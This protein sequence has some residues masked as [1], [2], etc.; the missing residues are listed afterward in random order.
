MFLEGCTQTLFKITEGFLLQTAGVLKM[1]FT[2]YMNSSSDFVAVIQ[3]FYVK[4]VVCPR[5]EKW[6]QGKRKD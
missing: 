5:A 2:T 6:R 4:S 3:I 1:L